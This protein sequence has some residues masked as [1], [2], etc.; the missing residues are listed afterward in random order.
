M[1]SSALVVNPAESGSPR[2]ENMAVQI[3]DH[4]LYAR[5]GI[6]KSGVLV[7]FVQPVNADYKF[8][9]PCLA[10]AHLSQDQPQVH[11]Y[12]QDLFRLHPIR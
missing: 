11:F 1:F 2:A 10:M 4:F 5:D 12:R 8:R 9:A 3:R 7:D 6:G